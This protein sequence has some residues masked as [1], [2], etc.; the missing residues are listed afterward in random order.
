LRQ[1]NSTTNVITR[2]VDVLDLAQV[3]AFWDDLSAQGLTV[4]V[5]VAND[6]INSDAKTMSEHGADNVWSFFE[7]NVR[8]PIYFTE[9]FSA[10]PND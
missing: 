10:Q 2:S 7:T 8:A 6:G 4:D 5:L 1:T 3:N 9:R